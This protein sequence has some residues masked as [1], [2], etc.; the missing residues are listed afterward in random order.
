MNSKRPFYILIFLLAFLA[1]GALVGG[2]AMIIS[3][4]G[5]LLRMPLSNLGNS[6]FRSF[7]IPGIILFMVLGLMPTIIIF[8]LLKKPEKKWFFVKVSG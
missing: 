7:L 5:E 8:A 6:P 4:S 3:P 1:F 2:G